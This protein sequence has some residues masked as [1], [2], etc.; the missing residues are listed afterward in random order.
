MLPLFLLEIDNATIIHMKT[1]YQT[2]LKLSK[3][4]ISQSISSENDEDS[5]PHYRVRYHC[6]VRLFD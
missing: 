1:D 3:Q 6:E 2:N 4:N 5:D